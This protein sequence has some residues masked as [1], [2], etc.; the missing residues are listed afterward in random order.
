MKAGR[1]GSESRS[2]EPETD[3]PRRRVPPSP[4]FRSAPL[5]APAPG[6]APEGPPALAQPSTA[7][8]TSAPAHPP[9]LLPLRPPADPPFF[10]ALG[11]GAL[12]LLLWALHFTVCYTLAVVG[13]TDA[14]GGPT[15]A[16]SPAATRT[17]VL[18]V[19]VPALAAA[20]TLA[21]RACRRLRREDSG[22]LAT[23]RL[24][25]AV[26]TL[27]GMAWTA[28][29]VLAS[30]CRA[31]DGAGPATPAATAASAVNPAP[32]PATASLAAVSPRASP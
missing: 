19:S 5:S 4:G 15:D 2:P 22:L 6:A 27:V 11:A 25:A 10:R 13:C 18:A 8:Q 28:V 30:A 14:E 3:G 32:S 31:G 20:A 16:L 17:V 29:P 23:V 24:A 1:E 7:A 12:P 9:P 21:W 26:L